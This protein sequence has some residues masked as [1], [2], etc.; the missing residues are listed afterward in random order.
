MEEL[1]KELVKEY[2]MNNIFFYI[3]DD[4]INLRIRFKNSKFCRKFYR[5]NEKIL[6]VQII[7]Y[8]DFICVFHPIDNLSIE[9]DESNDINK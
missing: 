4:Y 8:D 3:K 7:Y 2:N 6:L 1:S 9:L 5:F